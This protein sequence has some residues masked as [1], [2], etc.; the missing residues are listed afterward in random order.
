MKHLQSFLLNLIEEDDDDFIYSV[1]P[2]DW[3]INLVR[4][5][6]NLNA[7]RIRFLYRVRRF[8]EVYDEY[9]LKNNGHPPKNVFDYHKM[10]NVFDT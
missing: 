8:V 1:D 7:K 9:F 5:R 3:D 4:Q 6:S 2:N 10:L